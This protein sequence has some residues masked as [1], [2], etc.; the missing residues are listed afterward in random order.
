MQ[1]M[2]RRDFVK[3]VVVG[4]AVLSLDAAIMA[5]RLGAAPVDLKALGE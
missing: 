4:G 2:D 1:E 5:P 3:A